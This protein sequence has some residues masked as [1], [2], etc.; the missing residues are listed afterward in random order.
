VESLCRPPKPCRAHGWRCS[1]IYPVKGLT[2]KGILASSGCNAL[3]VEHM[4]EELPD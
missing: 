2:V 3:R 4:R 1:I